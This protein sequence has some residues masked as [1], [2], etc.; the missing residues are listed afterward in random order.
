MSIDRTNVVSTGNDVAPRYDKPDMTHITRR[1]L[2]L[3]TAAALTAATGALVVAP[4]AAAAPVGQVLCSFTSPDPVLPGVRATT[5]VS[6][7]SAGAGTSTF[8]FRTTTRTLLPY[9]QRASVIWSNLDT[10]LSGGYYDSQVTTTVRRGTT[11]VTLPTQAVGSGK[12]TVV[13]ATTNTSGSKVTNGDC[14][15]VYTAP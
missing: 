7:A 15:G 3:I 10:G 11:T 9:Q 14:S 6:V 13:A 1:S 4:T 2:P 8:T 12:I 5:E